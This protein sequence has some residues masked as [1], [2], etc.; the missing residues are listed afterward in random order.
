MKHYHKTVEP[1]RA[2]DPLVKAL[3][4]YM[5]E[6]GISLETASEKSGVS[7]VVLSNWRRG[8]NT[9]RLDLF[10]A[11]CEAVG[12]VLSVCLSSSKKPR[13]GSNSQME[14]EI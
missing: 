2:T 6:Q 10:A 8:L 14:L 13:K 4:K 1:I 5:S 7:A 12:V 9:P 11:V 3:F